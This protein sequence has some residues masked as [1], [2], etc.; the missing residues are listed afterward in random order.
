MIF[1]LPTMSST[2][3]VLGV[4]PLLTDFFHWGQ[5]IEA[6]FR[7][8]AQAASICCENHKSSSSDLTHPCTPGGLTC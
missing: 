2:A 1:R 8:S 3:E 7:Y 5:V 6:F 4:D